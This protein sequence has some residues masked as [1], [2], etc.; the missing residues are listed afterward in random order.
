MRV[1][2]ICETD[3][4]PVNAILFAQWH[5]PPSVSKG[6]LI[7]TTRLPGFLCSENDVIQGV[8]TY[9]I[10]HDQCEI[11]TLNSFAENRGIGTALIQAVIQAAKSQACKRLWL[12]TTNDD[13]NAIRFYQKRG[14]D[15]VAVHRNAMDV[16]RPLKPSIPTV[17]MHGIPIRHELEFEMLLG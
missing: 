3:R 5:C 16:S 2:P 7:D 9:H 6:N 1:H 8:I 13:I 11:V 17:G 10:S 12:I 14:F 4:D 15:L